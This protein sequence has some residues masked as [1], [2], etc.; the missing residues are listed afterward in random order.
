MAKQKKIVRKKPT[1]RKRG[2]SAAEEFASSSAYLK[3]TDIKAPYDA[4]VSGLER[5]EFDNG[6]KWVLNLEDESKSVVLNKI[7]G[8]SLAAD[9]GDDMDSWKGQQIH[10]S[11]ERR[12]NPQTGQ[13]VPAV[14]VCGAIEDIE[15]IEDDTEDYSDVEDDDDL[16]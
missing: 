13:M 15:D 3:G 7:N 14:A 8:A 4:V 1:S 2:P 5:I 11:T 10:V 12:R 6:T 9:L 16:E